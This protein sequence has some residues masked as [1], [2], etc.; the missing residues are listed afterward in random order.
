ME[1]SFELAL[2]CAAAAERGMA[3]SR[4]LGE[5]DHLARVEELA[6]LAWAAAVGAAEED[7]CADALEELEAHF[8]DDEDDPSQPEFFV[9]QST[10]LVGIALACAA[11]PSAAQAELSTNT[12]RTLLSMVDFR[13][14]GEKPV[15]LRYGETA[16]APGVLEQREVDAA[17]EVVDLL[18]EV[19]AG[20]LPA[21]AARIRLS[22]EQVG[23]RLEAALRA[24]PPW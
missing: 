13:L 16:P 12:M 5:P 6:E 3:F 18:R 10:A 2:V 22:A 4:V 23:A 21:A 9:D 17:R 1:T 24:V 7:E 19:G 14:A 15:V 8:D 11:R 20:D